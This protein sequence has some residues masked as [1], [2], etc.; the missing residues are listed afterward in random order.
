MYDVTRDLNAWVD[1]LEVELAMMK[2]TLVARDAK[3]AS[4]SQIVKGF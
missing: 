3:V 2:A 4:L 1:A